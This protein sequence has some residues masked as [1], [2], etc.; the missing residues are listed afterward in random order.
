[1]SLELELTGSTTYSVICISGQPGFTILISEQQQEDGSIVL[2]ALKPCDGGA[3]SV[4]NTFIYGPSEKPYENLTERW[5]KQIWRPR[6]AHQMGLFIERQSS[7][8]RAR[9]THF[10]YMLFWIK[11]A[12]QVPLDSDII[13]QIRKK[14]MNA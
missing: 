12:G 4:L 2:R 13:L 6:R 8:F 9:K 10:T 5:A 14:M 11:R 1:M 3:M 7:R